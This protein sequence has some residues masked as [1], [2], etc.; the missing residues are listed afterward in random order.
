MNQ[1]TRKLTSSKRTCIRALIPFPFETSRK[2][3]SWVE[4]T[5]TCECAY[6]TRPWRSSMVL[7]LN[8]PIILLF[9]Y[10]SNCFFCYT[11]EI[12][13]Q[14]IQTGPWN[15]KRDARFLCV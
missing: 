11:R 5:H 15:R 13:S 8:G 9:N 2:K 14:R 4:R 10:S 3:A 12:E 7:S 6:D 1:A